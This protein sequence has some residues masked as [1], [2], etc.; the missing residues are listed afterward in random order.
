MKVLYIGHYKEGTGWAKSAERIILSMTKAGIDVVCRN[1]TLTRDN[2]IPEWLS[3]LEQKEEQDIDICIQHVLPHMLV[4]TNRFKKNIAYTMFESNNIQDNIWINYLEIMDEVWVPCSEN[5]TDLINAG[6]KNVKVV[7]IPCD[8]EAIKQENKMEVNFDRYNATSS[9]KFYAISDLNK[10]KNI[11]SLIKCYYS[12]FGP[13]E[14]VSLILKVGKFGFDSRQIFQHME[15]MC[16]KIRED[17]AIYKDHDSYGDIIIIAERFSENEIKNLHQLCDCFVNL[18][19]GEAWSIPSFDAMS[20][21]NHPICTKWGGPCDYIL[22]DNKD[23]GYLIE[24]SQEIC[25]NEGAAFEH[26]FTGNEYW[27]RPDERMAVEAMR[28][29]FKQNKPKNKDGYKQ[30][31]NFN[32]QTVGEKIKEIINE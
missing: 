24:R 8:T 31:L 5:K 28:F 20:Y 15:K 12:A 27:A 30:A 19:H 17:L 32:L 3:E 21:G 11:E 16:K 23:T 4:G 2:P 14:N 6:I 29:Y 22:E 10:R 7:P 9:Y 1:I 13:E 25:S 18:S 26:I